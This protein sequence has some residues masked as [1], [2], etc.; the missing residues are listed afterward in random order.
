[1]GAS[2]KNT[3]RLTGQSCLKSTVETI[4]GSSDVL[5]QEFVPEILELG[6]FSLLYFN[7]KYSHAL[8]KFNTSGDFRDSSSINMMMMMMMTIM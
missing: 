5:I 3:W 7:G 8:R 1:M 6:E 2:G 4:V